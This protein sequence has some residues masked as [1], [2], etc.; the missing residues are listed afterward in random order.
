MKLFLA[1]LFF[2]INEECVFWKSNTNF[3]DAEECAAEVERAMEQLSRQ[4]VES[5][6]TCL[7]VNLN[8]HI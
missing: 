7:K 1:V 2:C 6:G 8:E 5:A 3:Y 4:G